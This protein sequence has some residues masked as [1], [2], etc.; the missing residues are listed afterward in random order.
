MYICI[1]YLFMVMK[2]ILKFM[3]LNIESPCIYKYTVLIFNVLQLLKKSTV[4]TS[5]KK[6]MPGH[7][8]HRCAVKL[9]AT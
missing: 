7:R 8:C 5:G 9:C 6:N 3:K 4:I 2:H 1:F